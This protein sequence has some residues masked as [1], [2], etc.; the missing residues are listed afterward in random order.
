MKVFRNTIERRLGLKLAIP[1]VLTIC[2]NIGL[3]GHSSQV[4]AKTA[5]PQGADRVVEINE[6][7]FQ[8]LVLKAQKPVLVDFYAT[9]CSPCKKLAPVISDLSSKYSDRVDFYRVDVDKNQNLSSRYGISG[10]PAL[11]VFKSGKAVAGTVGMQSSTEIT[12][13]LESALKSS[14][15]SVDPKKMTDEQWKAKLTPIQY[16]VT[17]QKGTERAF[18]GKYWDNH[19]EGMYKC[20]N[21]GETLFASNNKFDS[22][23]GWPS[24]D[25]PADK[26]GV[27]VNKDNSFGMERDEV[28]CSKC[29]AHLG[30]VFD[31]GPATTGKRY[32][33]NSASLD[34]KAAGD[35]GKNK[36]SK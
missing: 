14:E 23:T 1:L 2:S 18:S 32:C 16:E 35:S 15:L 29:G 31:D 25:R 26:R 30:H 5:T 10:I 9:W 34:F 19:K 3:A 27:T 6:S 12:S 36:S 11:K 21:C 22:G 17:R 33:I 7:N 13:L 20:S 28:V 8:T 4:N 24:F